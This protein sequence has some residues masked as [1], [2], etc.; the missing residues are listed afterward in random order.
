MFVFEGPHFTL[1]CCAIL[2]VFSSLVRFAWLGTRFAALG[3]AKRLVLS[4]AAETDV[5]PKWRIC[6][7]CNFLV[8]LGLVGLEPFGQL[9]AP[10]CWHVGE[11]SMSS[12]PHMSQVR[13][14]SPSVD[15]AGCTI[16]VSPIGAPASRMSRKLCAMFSK[17]SSLA[18]RS[19][20][21]TLLSNC[22][23]VWS[24]LASASCRVFSS[25]AIS[26]LLLGLHFRFAR[27][28]RGEPPAAIAGLLGVGAS[29]SNSSGSID[30]PSSSR[31]MSASAAF[32]LAITAASSPMATPFKIWTFN[33]SAS[34]F[35][36]ACSI[37]FS[38]MNRF[39]S[40]PSLSSSPKT[41][42]ALLP[43]D[44]ASSPPTP[45]PLSS[46]IRMRG[47]WPLFTLL[48]G[49]DEN[50]S[51]TSVLGGAATPTTALRGLDPGLP[52]VRTPKPASARFRTAS[53]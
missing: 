18:G 52:C 13:S 6:W 8:G 39:A 24:L 45:S 47:S 22:C 43:I 19:L 5:E 14:M 51:L 41:E 38:A 20:W 28:P 2:A 10:H 37:R 35:N 46:S 30:S 17:T 23:K 42:E 53:V 33:S 50:A 1:Q 48:R 3:D 34:K 32:A 7:P 15:F 4:V 21:A 44:S 49:K 40:T 9:L 25:S 27:C 16:L 12:A 36:K 31:T 29:W 26:F 11:S